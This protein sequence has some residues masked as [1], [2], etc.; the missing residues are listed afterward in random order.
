MSWD[1]SFSF[2]TVQDQLSGGTTIRTAVTIRLLSSHNNSTQHH[3]L[4]R[5]TCLLPE[6]HQTVGLPLA[7]PSYHPTKSS[8]TALS[9]LQTT[10]PKPPS[11]K[12]LARQTPAS[13][14][15][16]QNGSYPTTGPLN[17][18]LDRPASK[19]AVDRLPAHGTRIKSRL[20][21]GSGGGI[22]RRKGG[23]W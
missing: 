11:T 10:F 2:P 19:A 6:H 16:R 12:R 7:P 21:R 18:A 13:P 14:Q 20:Q 22:R 5:T 3:Q 9:S 1:A 4:Q 17:T 8:Q 23:T 15:K